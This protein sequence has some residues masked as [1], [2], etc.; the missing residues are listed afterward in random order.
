MLDFLPYEVLDKI[1]K[2][3]SAEN[4]VQLSFTNFKLW[5]L[6]Q[7]ESLWSELC[8][9]DYK[10]K[11]SLA[12]KDQSQNPSQ[13]LYRYLYLLSNNLVGLWHRNIPPHAG[14]LRVSRDEQ[15]TFTGVW[16]KAEGGISPNIFR[17]RFEDGNAVY[18]CQIGGM[19]HACSAA[20]GTC[21]V[22]G[23]ECE[24]LRL[25]CGVLKHHPSHALQYI[26]MG[27]QFGF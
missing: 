27:K 5:N 13:N 14:Y 11:L 1:L 20:S 7:D 23:V 26:K 4:V 17:I 18:E 8:E 15:G 16:V 12:E 3:V 21:L 19:S 25:G 6:C 9:R 10:M 2:S 24:F 22:S